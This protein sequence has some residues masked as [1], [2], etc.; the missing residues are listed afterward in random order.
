MK[1]YFSVEAACILPLVLGV[2]VL[3]VYGMFFLYDRCLLEQD[4][5][6]WVTDGTSDCARTGEEMVGA[7]RKQ[8]SGFD[9]DRLLACR[10]GEWDIKA[11][12]G[13][14]SAE[15]E[16]RVEVPF[17]GLAKWTGGDGW[18]IRAS[19]SCVSLSPALTVRACRKLLD[20]LEK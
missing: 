13:K 6:W 19:H 7:V 9:W 1:A 14:L 8:A 3:L 16:S 12:L 18:R 10:P 11:S 2:Q 5:A 20:A 15:V 4:V 17:S